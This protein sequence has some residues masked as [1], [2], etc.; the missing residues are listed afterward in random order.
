M[1]PH[2]DNSTYTA[3][4]IIEDRGQH[5]TAYIVILCAGKRRYLVGAQG[6]PVD[7]KALHKHRVAHPH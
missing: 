3:D 1:Q 5:R 6:E 7:A 2:Q 4:S